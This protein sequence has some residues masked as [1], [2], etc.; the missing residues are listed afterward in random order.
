VTLSGQLNLNSEWLPDLPGDR[1]DILKRTTPSHGLLPRPV[2][3]FENDLPRLWLLTD[4][5]RTPRRDV[6]GVFNWESKEQE[7]ECP[8]DRLGLDPK[9]EYEAFDYWQNAVAPAIQDRLRIAVPAETCRILAVRPRVAHPQLLSTSR[10][11]TQGMVDVLEERWDAADRTLRGRSKVVG[12]DPYELRILARTAS[13]QWVP[14]AVELSSED[15][16]AGVSAELAPGDTLVRTKVVSASSR[17]V[18]WAVRF[19]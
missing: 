9:I 5:R 3:L 17:E 1:L 11:I 7:L 12:G 13:R 8:L 15:K 19:K 18:S 16:L 2:D 6:I 10:H 14:D 4:T